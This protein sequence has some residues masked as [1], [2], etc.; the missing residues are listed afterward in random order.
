MGVALATVPKSSSSASQNPR[1]FVAQIAGTG[2]SIS[3]GGLVLSGSFYS[4]RVA[5]QRR[6]IRSLPEVQTRHA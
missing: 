6:G 2:A 3:D 5:S 1:R 4:Q